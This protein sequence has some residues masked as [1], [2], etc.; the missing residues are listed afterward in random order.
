MLLNVND[1]K[2]IETYKNLFNEFVK[3]GG[4]VSPMNTESCR[5]YIENKLNKEV[6]PEDILW[7]I[8]H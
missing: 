1:K 6:C 2:E 4:K 3:N 7:L 8:Y 5:R